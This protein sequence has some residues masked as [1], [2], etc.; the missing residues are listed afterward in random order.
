MAIIG[1]DLGTTNSAVA[2]MEDGN[3][4][5]IPNKAGD[6][7]MPSVV[8]YLGDKVLVGKEAKNQAI[9]NPR[10]TISSIKR[11][12]G[13]RVK[14]VPEASKHVSYTLCGR[15]N[16]PVMVAIEGKDDPL[17]PSEISAKILSE[18]KKQAEEY[19]G[20]PVTDA[21]ITVPAYFNDGQRHATKQAGKLAGLN[22]KRIINEPTAAALAY[23][24]REGDEQGAKIAVFDLGGGT[25]DISVLELGG[26]IVEVKATNGDTF[27]GGD[28]FN[29][30]IVNLLVRNFQDTSGIDIR[31]NPTAMQRLRDAAEKAKHELSDNLTT[32]ITQAFILEDNNQHL[33]FEL[34]RAKF[35]ALIEK[36][37]KRIASCCQRVMKDAGVTSNDI[38]TV[39]LV[40]GSTRVPAV[41]DLA[42][43]IFN[44]EPNT[45]VNP[46]EVVSLGAAIQGAIL[47]G[48]KKDMILV[49]VTPLS[50]GIETEFEEMDVLI[51]RNTAIPCIKKEIYTTTEDDQPEVE[52]FVYQGEYK[53][54]T[55]NRLLG[56]FVLNNIEPAS[57]GDP[58]IEV[59]FKID[60]DGILQVSAKNVA[61]GSEHSIVIKDSSTIS[62]SDIEKMCKDAA[63]EEEDDEDYIDSIELL[64]AAEALL[65]QTDEGLEEFE[66]TGELDST[67]IN[68]LKTAKQ[69]L[70][71]AI[72]AE[73]LDSV[74]AATNALHMLWEA[75]SAALEE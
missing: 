59:T 7:T 5:V 55:K 20:T 43:K 54:V 2:I 63:E 13:L 73:D 11:V 51:A 19:L 57:A 25:F 4:K 6:N 9:A 34:T 69:N 8:A 68:T 14:E 30:E 49:D 65:E 23:G 18:L 38:S 24:F 29:R 44:K 1:I 71:A 31:D 56:Q 66:A 39:V 10:E 21:V 42:R 22:V 27:L 62:D 17:L 48:E 52:V 40:G 61:T 16:D 32:T 64:E 47:S 36:Y 58:Q 12:I 15:L 3:S 74:E 70:L 50:L 35:E 45:S 28:D 60:T 72:D 75:T 67:I 53:R 33:E 26:G 37:L 46:D 41:K